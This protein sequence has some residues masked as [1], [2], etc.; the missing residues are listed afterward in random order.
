[1]QIPQL[2]HA[3]ENTNSLL[4]ILRCVT[5][6]LTDDSH[7]RQRSHFLLPQDACRTSWQVMCNQP[8]FNVSKTKYRKLVANCKLNPHPTA[9]ACTTLH[10]TAKQITV[11][12]AHKTHRHVMQRKWKP[13]Q[14]SWQLTENYS[15][16]VPQVQV[17]SSPKSS[18]TLKFQ[19]ISK[20]LFHSNLSLTALSSQL[21]HFSSQMSAASKP[22]TTTRPGT[23]TKTYTLGGDLPTQTIL[24]ASAANL[25]HKLPF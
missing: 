25:Y 20:L 23:T 5:H 11:V 1:M 2:N 22:S 10:K 14:N 21:L 16:W 24:W 15:N 13:V 8:N 9:N 17:L 12:S 7:F 6:T 4:L 3:K 18:K 19:D